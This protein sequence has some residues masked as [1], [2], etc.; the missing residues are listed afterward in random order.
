MNKPSAESDWDFYFCN[1][2]GVL[3]SIMVDLEANRRAPLPGKP[4]LLWVWVHMRF[5]RD[6]GLSSDQEAPTLHEI[7]DFLTGS[8][9]ES[10]GE[11]LGRITG[12]HRREFYFYSPSSEG[13]D[14]A[15]REVRQAFPEYVFECGTHHDPRLASI[16]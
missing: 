10:D 14:S 16:S 8:L 12:D 15:I 5:P 2:N 6:D 11:L 1:V 3:S 13:V 4:W 9:S 7:E